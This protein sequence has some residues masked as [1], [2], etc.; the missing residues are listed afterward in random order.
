MTKYF[1][2]RINQDIYNDIRADILM[3]LNL[4]KISCHLKK[5]QLLQIGYDYWFS[6]L[7]ISESLLEIMGEMLQH[8][9]T[10]K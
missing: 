9:L 10:T 1:S 8:H 4:L 5:I 3:R 7:Q 6:G 2:I